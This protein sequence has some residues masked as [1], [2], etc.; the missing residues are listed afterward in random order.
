[1]AEVSIEP[2]SL[3]QIDPQTLGVIWKDD[4]VSE[5]SCFY[6]R[7]NCSCAA[8]VSEMTGEK[9]L[10]EKNIKPDIKP[11][12]IKSVGRYAIQI[13]WDD[14]H[15]SGIYDFKRLRALCPCEICQ[16]L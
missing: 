15:S 7:S 8:C 3:K 13:F 11:D 4:H 1:M 16:K 9:I 6:L 5:F 14:G 12:E 2:K 10:D